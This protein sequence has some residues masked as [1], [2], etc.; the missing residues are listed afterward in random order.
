MH[1]SAGLFPISQRLFPLGLFKFRMLRALRTMSFADIKGLHGHEADE[2]VDK[3]MIWVTSA[4]SFSFFS[5][6]SEPVFRLL[7]VKKK[8]HFQTQE[9]PF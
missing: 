1:P 8:N 6:R 9:I 4:H 3:I 2:L 7:E 5:R